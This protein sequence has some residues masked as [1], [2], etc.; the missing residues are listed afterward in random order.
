MDT[1]ED[2]R[3]EEEVY[4]IRP[5]VVLLEEEE[6]KAATTSGGTSLMDKEGKEYVHS[7]LIGIGMEEEGQEE[8]EE[9]KASSTDGKLK[10]V[11]SAIQEAYMALL[12]SRYTQ[13]TDRDGGGA[14][15]GAGQGFQHQQHRR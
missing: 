14:G 7:R 12:P 8:L 13:P 5:V 15:A 9:V 6:A 3:E 11:E 4:V 2:S 1:E 10:L